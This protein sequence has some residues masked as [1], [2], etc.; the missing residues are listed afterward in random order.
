MTPNAPTPGGFTAPGAPQGARP[1]AASHR[2]GP[3][4]APGCP[5]R[6]DRARPG[7]LR[8]APGLRTRPAGGGAPGAAGAAGSCSPTTPPAPGPPARGSGGRASTS[9]N[10]PP[11]PPLAARFS[12]T[13]PKEPLNQPPPAAHTPLPRGSAAARLPPSPPPLRAAAPLG[14][15]AAPS[16]PLSQPGRGNCVIA[17]ENRTAPLLPPPRP[18]AP[19]RR[20]LPPARSPPR[21]APQPAAPGLPA[22]LPAPAPRPPARHRPPRTRGAARPRRP[23]QV[24]RSRAGGRAWRRASQARAAAE[25]A[26]ERGA[27]RRYSLTAA[28]SECIFVRRTHG[29]ARPGSRCPSP[30]HRAQARPPTAPPTGGTHW[31]GLLGILLS[32]CVRLLPLSFCPPRTAS[33]S[34]SRPPIGLVAERTPPPFITI[35]R[36][37]WQ[38]FLVLKA[39]ATNSTLCQPCLRLAAEQEG[40]AHG[41]VRLA[42]QGGGRG[43]CREGQP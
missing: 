10:A 22:A 21:A 35:G 14:P 17:S 3:P 11:V 19:P 2:R 41:P 43:L 34:R 18:H 15:P 37:C 12:R 38:S 29:P 40:R 28:A 13:G 20:P 25:R 30:N 1:G 4:N 9:H 33:L 26:K 32:Y 8:S 27:A 16:P 24:R 31:L 5:Q 39:R 7:G 36:Y 23:S 6:R 42:Q